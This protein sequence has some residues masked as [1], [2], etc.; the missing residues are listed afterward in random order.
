MNNKGLVLLY[1]LNVGWASLRLEHLN[2]LNAGPTFLI[3][4]FDRSRIGEFSC[5]LLLCFALA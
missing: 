3:A 4:K 1:D 5:L 2:R